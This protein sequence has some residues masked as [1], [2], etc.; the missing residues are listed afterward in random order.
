M[1]PSQ[2]IKAIAFGSSSQCI[3]IW[4]DSFSALCDSF[5]HCETFSEKIQNFLGA[6]RPRGELSRCGLIITPADIFLRVR[7]LF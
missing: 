1:E 6:L 3:K 4:N 7:I 5:R 2:G